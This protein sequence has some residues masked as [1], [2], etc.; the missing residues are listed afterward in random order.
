[1]VHPTKGLSKASVQREGGLVEVVLSELTWPV[2]SSLPDQSDIPGSTKPD[3]NANRVTSW[4]LATIA[5]VRAPLRIRLSVG[6]RGRKRS[7]YTPMYKPN[8]ACDTQRKKTSR[9]SGR[10]SS[11]RHGECLTI[12]LGTQERT[13]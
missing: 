3:S 12:L 11:G 6:P 2:R 10:S 1:M 4:R 13:Q 7:G 9:T 5:G 8:P